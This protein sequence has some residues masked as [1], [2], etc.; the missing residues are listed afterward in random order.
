LITYWFLI[1]RINKLIKELKK[2][3]SVAKDFKGNIKT[4]AES[5]S[6]VMN[7]FKNP[8]RIKGK[9]PLGEIDTE[10]SAGGKK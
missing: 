2:I 3:G 5:V 10:I 9:T 8:I 1:W 6:F 4:T 7:F